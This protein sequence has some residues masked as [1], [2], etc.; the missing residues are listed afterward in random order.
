MMQF[1]AKIKDS[2]G[3]SIGKAIVN[4]DLQRFDE[5]WFLLPKSNHISILQG[6]IKAKKGIFYTKDYFDA[7]VNGVR[8]NT[9]HEGVELT[10]SKTTEIMVKFNLKPYYDSKLTDKPIDLYVKKGSHLKIPL[11]EDSAFNY[12]C[13]FIQKPYEY[14]FLEFII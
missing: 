13:D 9:E 1:K 12:E 4:I 2:E 8:I 10:F 5:D 14:C 6:R 11:S 7:I 3:N